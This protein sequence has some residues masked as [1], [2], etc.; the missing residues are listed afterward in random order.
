MTKY[1]LFSQLKSPKKSKQ[2]VKSVQMLSFF[3]VCI[4]PYSVQIQENKD[5]KNS[6][7]GHFPRSER[8]DKSDKKMKKKPQIKRNKQTKTNKQTKKQKTEIKKYKNSKNIKAV[9][10]YFIMQTSPLNKFIVSKPIDSSI[11]LFRCSIV[12]TILIQLTN[13]K[14]YKH[15]EKYSKTGHQKLKQNIFSIFA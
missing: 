3:L 6:V 1:V 2:F 5:Q 13:K 4:F 10:C 14:N 11:A 12:P 7:F 9:G 15:N 8:K